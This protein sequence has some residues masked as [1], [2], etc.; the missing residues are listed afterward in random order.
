MKLCIY[1]TMSCEY[2]SKAITL[3]D[4]DHI[5]RTCLGDEKVGPISET[6]VGDL[7]A[8]DLLEYCVMI[9][10]SAFFSSPPK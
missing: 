2:S 1:L 5:C 7:K 4:F 9:E 3:K 8:V 6:T 10:V